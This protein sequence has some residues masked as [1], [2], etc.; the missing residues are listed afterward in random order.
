MS[1]TSSSR[2]RVPSYREHK[3]SG[4]AVVTL[5]GHDVYL[6][7]WGSVESHQKYDRVISD[8]IANDRC[9]PAKSS[10][11]ITIVELVETYW[12]F[13]TGYYRKNGLQTDTCYGI[14]AALRILLEFYGRSLAS[15]F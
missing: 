11:E 7:P 1:I 6:G 15:E 8:W 13:A 2:S 14:K 5:S 3:P 10:A 9:W 4:Q 12:D